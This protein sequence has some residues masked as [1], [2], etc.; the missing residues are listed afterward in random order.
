M[1]LLFL[2]QLKGG[3]GTWQKYAVNSA[4]SSAAHGGTRP[5]SD[6][7]RLTG[8]DPHAARVRVCVADPVYS[9][10]NPL[11]CLTFQM[12]LR[13]FKLYFLWVQSPLRSL[14]RWVTATATTAAKQSVKLVLHQTQSSQ[15]HA[16]HQHCSPLSPLSSLWHLLL[17]CLWQLGGCQRS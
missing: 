14:S 2:I 5:A 4:Q 16:E 15:K 10:G 13:T 8:S 12:M 11:V 6:A 9:N 3:K 17:W 1:L 7:N